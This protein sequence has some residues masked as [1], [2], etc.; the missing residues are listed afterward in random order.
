MINQF[1]VHEKI[2]NRDGTKIEV[3][4]SQFD[5]NNIWSV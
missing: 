4:L 3:R 5:E 2:Y 1:V